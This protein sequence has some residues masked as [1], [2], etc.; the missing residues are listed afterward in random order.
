MR[1]RVLVKRVD[2]SEFYKGIAV[3][4][5]IMALWVVWLQ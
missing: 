3:G 2:G 1:A 5:S 4:M